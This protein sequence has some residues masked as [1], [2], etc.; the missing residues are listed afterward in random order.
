M[1]KIFKNK[2]LMIMLAAILLLG[3][4]A[5]ATSADRSV[6]WIESAAG[7]VVQPVQTFAAKASNEIISFFQRVF[8]TTDAD[9]ELEQLKVRMAQLEAAEE[10]NERLKAENERLKA[11]LNYVETLG[12]YEYVTA[13]VIGNSQGVWFET[14]TI[15]AGRNKGIKKDMA[16][17]SSSGLVGR[18]TDVGATWSKVTSIIDTSSE[19]SVMIER[20]R[21][22]GIAHG[23]FSVSGDNK[24]ELYYLP[25]GYDLVPG[26]VIVTSGMSDVFP[27]G[28]L[29]GTVSEVERQTADSPSIT[30]NAIIV[31]AVDFGHLEEVIVIVG[32]TGGEG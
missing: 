4:L 18:V 22:V 13:T 17:I 11:L 30:R 1:K 2:P 28:I 24:I 6:T 8:K 15:N 3:V 12:D 23:L 14:F 20:T 16:V 27:K 32:A 21:D 10:E 7:S 5:F 31:P 19:V 29:V 26:D 9:K 25:S